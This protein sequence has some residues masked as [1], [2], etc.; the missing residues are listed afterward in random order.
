MPKRK[1]KGRLR[2]RPGFWWLLFVANTAVGLMTS[3]LTSATKV[4]VE[5]AE[6]FD[7]DRIAKELRP[8]EGQPWSAGAGAKV[9]TKVLALPDVRTARL[10]QNLFGRG[11]LQLTYRDAVAQLDKAPGM[12]LASDGTVYL[13][14]RKWEGLPLLSLDPVLQKPIVGFW[15]PWKPREV[16]NVCRALDRLGSPRE[17]AVRVDARGAVCLNRQSGG[18]IV[19][20]STEDLDAKLDK[21]REAL[22]EEPTLLRPGFE[23]DVTVP[24]RAVLRRTDSKEPS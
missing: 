10:S 12:V 14:T 11:L 23:F 1:K 5:G 24:D 16:A 15:Q 13:S 8:L 21:V 2:L 9:Q 6:P 19:L 17:F 22:R 3:P 4:A 20:G 18:S 7:R